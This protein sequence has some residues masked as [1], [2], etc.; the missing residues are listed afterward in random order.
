[1][2]S[3]ILLE[4]AGI[5]KVSYEAEE[6]LQ[7]HEWFD[8]NPEDR[9]PLILQLL[10]RIYELLLEYPVEKVLVKTDNVRGAFSPRVQVFIRDVQFPRLVAD[11]HIRFVATVKSTVFLERIGTEVWRSQLKKHAPLVTHDVGSEAEARQWLQ[12][13]ASPSGQDG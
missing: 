12:L 5:L 2:A 1:M 13:V 11:T 7:I 6:G 4:E 10:E 3:V 8:Y 9:D